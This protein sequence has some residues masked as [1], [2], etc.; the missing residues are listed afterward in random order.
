M[1]C[2]SGKLTGVKKYTMKPISSERP[3]VCK[4]IHLDEQEIFGRSHL[5]FTAIEPVTQ[6]HLP[7]QHDYQFF[8]ANGMIFQKMF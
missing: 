2:W 3:L 5:Y 1:A 6:Q 8:M 4:S 7:W